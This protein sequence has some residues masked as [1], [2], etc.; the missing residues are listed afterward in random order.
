ML[1][2]TRVGQSVDDHISVMDTEEPQ[3][4]VAAPSI[5]T[6]VEEKEESTNGERERERERESSRLQVLQQ[7]I[8]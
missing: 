4:S 8:A 1:Q 7:Q 3:Q 5:T 2:E 6:I